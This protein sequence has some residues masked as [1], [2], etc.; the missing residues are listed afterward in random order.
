LSNDQIK[1]NDTLKTRVVVAAFK[2]VGPAT[3]FDPSNG[4]DYEQFVDTIFPTVFIQNYGL[5]NQGP[6]GVRAEIYDST[7][8]LV[9]SDSKSY[10]LT[11]LNSILASF[12]PFPCDIKGRYYFRAFTQLGI[13]V[14]KTND[15]V[16]RYFNI[17]RSNDVAITSIIY[18]ENGKSYAPPVAAK[19]PSAVLENLGELNQA[20][21]FWN[22]CDIYF[23]NSIIYHDSFSINSFRGSPE[24]LL[25]KNFK[26]T[27]KGY[28]KML[29]Y[30]SLAEDQYHKNDT[31]LS[32]FAVGLPDDI[33][34][35][36]ITPAPG[37]NLQLNVPAATGFTLKNN[38]YN[39]QN[40]PFPVI[41]KVT[42]GNSIKYVKVKMVTID[43]GETKLFVIDTTLLLD[44]L[45]P[46]KVSVYTS[47]NKD[48]NKSNDTITGVF[49]VMKNYDVSADKIL[50]P[51]NSDTLLVNTQ[52]VTPMVSIRN[53]GDSLYKGRFQVVLKISNAL[54]GVVFYNKTIDTLMS[55]SG[56]LILGFPIFGVSNSPLQIKLLSYV[57]VPGDQ[58][59]LNDTCKANSR[60]LIRYDA[61]AQSIQVPASG[62]VYANSTNTLY[63]KLVL[64]NNGVSDMPS[65]NA[66]AIITHLDTSTKTEVEVY[67]DSLS[68]ST[69]TVGL[70]LSVDLLKAFDV[71][72]MPN[73]DY[74]CYLAVMSS[75]DQ[76]FNNDKTSIA[77]K[78]NRTNSI[79]TINV[80]DWRIYPNPVSD[81]L[82]VEIKQTNQFVIGHIYDAYG[83]VLKSM[84]L[85][86]G[87]TAVDVR[88]LSAGV[89]FVKVGD[90]LIKF[91]V[92]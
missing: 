63:P 3:I 11:A 61:Q 49:G 72:S 75:S 58:E 53:L 15:T 12:K 55:D 69:L 9:Y 22:Y 37:S 28:Y 18:P 32:V 41:Y 27:S 7:N 33:E 35:V 31:L 1:D 26:P 77:F 25:F 17:V 46:Y 86:P 5:D 30:T 84:L 51:T 39:P 89:Y 38:G 92:E 6:F 71:T 76:I 45:N 67:R 85:V 70:T 21:P 10:T 23:N 14:D 44:N 2:D 56:H 88:D 40:T 57:T 78:I 13:D 79:Q 24:T 80:S 29:V 73:G 90:G 62:A 48:F 81:Q 43:S 34:V 36:S 83:R 50:F 74:K 20:T 87:T 65:F 64:K 19:K 47:L 68:V 91:V 16:K 4:Y 66:R 54:N 52:N 82:F 42:Q 8:A 60:F 59:K